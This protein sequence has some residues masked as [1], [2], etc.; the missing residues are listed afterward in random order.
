MPP[1][2]KTAL[3]LIVATLAIGWHAA[4][5]QTAWE[6]SGKGASPRDFASYYYADLALDHGKD[7]Y[8]TRNLR[9]EAR[10]TAQFKNI[11]PFFYPP[12]FLALTTWLSKLDIRTAYQV[13]F[14]FD[15]LAVLAI[16]LS[17]GWWWRR[18]GIGVTVLMCLSLATLTA[19]PNNH[20]MGQAN[21]PVLALVIAALWADSEG[22]SEIGG[23]LMGVACMLKMSPALFVAWWLLRGRTTSVLWACGMGLFL[24]IVTL[25]VMPFDMQWRFYTEVLPTFGTGDYNGLTVSIGLFGN[26]SIPDIYNAIWPS[27]DRVLSPT[28][29]IMSTTTALLLPA[30][31][32]YRL[33]EDPADAWAAAGQVGALC[34]TILLIPVYTYEHHLVFAIPAAVAT[35]GAAFHGRLHKAWIPVLLLAWVAWS[36]DLPWMKRMARHVAGT[37]W[38][39]VI[40]ESKFAALLVFYAASLW[41][42]SAFHLPTK[43]E[44]P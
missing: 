14:W 31:T 24:S 7:P 29:Q 27:P 11:H 32:L 26:H 22:R 6:H 30:L 41:L 2:L 20:V 40:E 35:L 44:S 33:R 28:A 34:V 8:S 4:S 43:K 5:V 21:F 1:R 17:L 18:L 37:P 23:S 15:E 10:K 12:P 16:A 39:I 3:L 9:A 19:I 13:W 25:L 38:A 42:G 36:A